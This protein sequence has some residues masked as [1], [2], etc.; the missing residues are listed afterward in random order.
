MA[1]K[2]CSKP[3]RPIMSRVA[4]LT[5][6]PTSMTTRSAFFS[7]S[8]LLSVVGVPSSLLVEDSPRLVSSIRRAISWA[9]AQKI[10]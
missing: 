3:A 6:E 8:L 9:L 4:R 2:S 10:G 1:L 7:P 5:V